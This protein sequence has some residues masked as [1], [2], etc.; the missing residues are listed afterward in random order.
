MKALA[1]LSYP[2]F[3]HFFMNVTDARISTTKTDIKI[4][5]FGPLAKLAIR[6]FFNFS[7]I[8]FSSLARASLWIIIE[9]KFFVKF[10]PLTHP[11]NLLQKC[12]LCIIKNNINNS[13]TS[14]NRTFKCRKN[15]KLSFFVKKTVDYAKEWLYNSNQQRTYDLRWSDIRHFENEN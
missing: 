10:R 11:F 15:E 5:A 4:F 13:N 1:C 3:R 12:T 9:F 7:T 6:Y 8:Y 2:M 14:V